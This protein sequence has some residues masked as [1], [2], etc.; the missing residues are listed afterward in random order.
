MAGGSLGYETAKILFA[1]LLVL[2]PRQALGRAIIV[3]QFQKQR[4]GTGDVFCH[5]PTRHWFVALGHKGQFSAS[6]LP[7]NAGLT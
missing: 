1:K 6:F 7:A 4:C 5:A 3:Q 2:I